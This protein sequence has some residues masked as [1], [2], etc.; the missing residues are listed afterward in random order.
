MLH[1]PLSSPD[2]G[3]AD[4]SQ[5]PTTGRLLPTGHG[6]SL[7]WASGR[8]PWPVLQWRHSGLSTAF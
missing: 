7:S 5:S 4:I 2:V 8:L 1:P 3:V 6:S